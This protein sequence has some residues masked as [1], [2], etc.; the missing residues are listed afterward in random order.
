M[1]RLTAETAAGFVLARVDRG[2][3]L[4]PYPDYATLRAHAPLCRQPD[5]SYV[6]TRYADIREVLGDSEAAINWEI[7]Q[8]ALA[9]ATG[10]PVMV[11][12]ELQPESAPQGEP[13]VPATGPTGSAANVARP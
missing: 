7:A 10:L 2:F 6:L 5:G 9:G 11:G 3:A 12:L 1:P 8:A 4:D 13:G